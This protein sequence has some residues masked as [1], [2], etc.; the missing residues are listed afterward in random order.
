MNNKKCNV[1]SCN[2]S[3]F[4]K[5][6]CKFHVPK[7]IKERL[8]FNMENLHSL[9]TSDLKRVADY[10]LRQYLLRY[11]SG[12]GERIW[13]PL[14]KQSYHVSKMQVAHFI[15]RACMNT[16]YDL[17]NCHLVSEQ[18]NVWDAQIPKEGYKSLHHY[19]YEMWLG[20]EK[21]KI[22]LEKSKI[23]SKFAK[24]DYIEIINSFKNEY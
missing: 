3:A 8:D 7:K 14:K 22:L 23:I 2:N 17:D 20:E 16:R 21:V 15:D 9:S 1:E 18:S 5:G 6:F 4:S 12:F 24:E 13:C 11:S 10:W 19:E